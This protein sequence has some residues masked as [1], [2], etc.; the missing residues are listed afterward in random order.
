[1]QEADIKWNALAARLPDCGGGNWTLRSSIGVSQQIV[2]LS[3]RRQFQHSLQ[4]H[5]V[6]GEG[7]PACRRCPNPGSRLSIHELLVVI[8]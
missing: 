1:M 3:L 7:T 6:I 5:Q 4:I 2:R 8:Y